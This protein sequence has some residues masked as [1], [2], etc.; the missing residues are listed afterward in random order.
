[1]NI[2][3]KLKCIIGINKENKRGKLCQRERIK[4][5]VAVSQEMMV[6]GRVEVTGNGNEH[7]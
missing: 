6:Q 2:R 4:V 3:N 1:M 7:S 5:V